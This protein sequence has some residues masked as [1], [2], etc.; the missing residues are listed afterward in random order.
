MNTQ[1]TGSCGRIA[2]IIAMAF[3]SGPLCTATQSDSSSVPHIRRSAVHVAIASRSSEPPIERFAHRRKKPSNKNYVPLDSVSVGEPI[4]STGEPVL[5]TVLMETGVP[6]ATNITVRVHEVLIGG[7]L[8]LRRVMTIQVDRTQYSNTMPLPVALPAGSYLIEAYRLDD[9]SLVQHKLVGFRV[10]SI[11]AS[12]HQ[13]GPNRQPHKRIPTLGAYTPISLQTIATNPGLLSTEDY[14]SL[15]SSPLTFNVFVRMQWT[16]ENDPDYLNNG[17]LV[18]TLSILDSTLVEV[19]NHHVPVNF[20]SGKLTW[21]FPSPFTGMTLN[22]GQYYLRT[23]RVTGNTP[24]P[25]DYM[26]TVQ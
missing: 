1:G 21:V 11:R 7:A 15:V 9:P 12:R 25:P 16:T 13:R 23:R 10:R 4:K 22:P 19:S 5:I 20:P 14:A 2:T 18:I 8:G 26:F 3:A 24:N 17:N 6:V